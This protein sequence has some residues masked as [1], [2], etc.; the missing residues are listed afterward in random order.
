MNRITLENITEIAVLFGR[1]AEAGNLDLERE[2]SATERLYDNLEQW[3]DEFEAQ[4]SKED[5][6]Y[7]EAIEALGKRKF[8]E[9]GWYSTKS[10]QANVLGGRGVQNVCLQQNW[11]M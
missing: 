10:D 9:M 11:R 8:Q 3:S 1:M 5:D 2:D 7:Y 6:D 4:Y